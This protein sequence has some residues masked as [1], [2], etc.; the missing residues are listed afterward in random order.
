MSKG[1]QTI[2]LSQSEVDQFWQDGLLVLD[3]YTYLSL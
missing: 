1:Q 2:A 3:A